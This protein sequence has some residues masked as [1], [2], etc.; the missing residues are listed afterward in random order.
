MENVSSP[1]NK[2]GARIIFLTVIL[3]YTQRSVSI[4]GRGTV[5]KAH[6]TKRPVQTNTLSLL[7]TGPCV[8]QKYHHS[9]IVLNASIGIR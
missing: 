7:V 1:N 4:R 2:R 8:V 9:H 6:H 5:N 3:Y